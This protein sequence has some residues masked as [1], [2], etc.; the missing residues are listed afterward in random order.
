ML[1]CVGLVAVP[2]ALVL[3]GALSGEGTAD[4]GAPTTV[5]G[6]VESVRAESD[7]RVPVAV[8]PYAQ[9]YF[10]HRSEP[11][12]EELLRLLNDAHSSQ[13]AVRCTFRR[14]S[15]RIVAVE[16]ADLDDRKEAA[17]WTGTAQVDVMMWEPGGEHPY[18]TTFDLA[19]REAGRTPVLDANGVVRGHEVRLVPERVAIDVHHEVRHQ[20]G[21]SICKGGGREAV[22]GGPEGRIRVAATGRAL[23]GL[24]GPRASAYQLVLP[25]AVGAFACGTRKN[26][27]DRRV[28]IGARLF[29]PVD[30]A[31]EIETADASVRSLDSGGLAMKGVFESSDAATGRAVRHDYT[32]RWELRRGVQE[33]ATRR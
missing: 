27:R 20:D 24:D 11:G 28:V 8:R 7:G 18:T 22:T 13:R 15:G 9:M 2:L 31:A 1:A 25:R 21:R 32:V 19:Y 26:V 17:L 14:Y 30:P 6:R 12:F 10:L 29:D 33:R 23:P 4:E 16:W 5:T 3:G